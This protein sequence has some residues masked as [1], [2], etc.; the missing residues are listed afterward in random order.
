[1]RF[2]YMTCKYIRTYYALHYYSNI[3]PVDS[4][5]QGFTNTQ[6]SSWPAIAAQ[7]DWHF[8]GLVYRAKLQL[9]RGCAV[10][11]AAPIGLSLPNTKPRRLKYKGVVQETLHRHP[12]QSQHVEKNV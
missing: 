1:M 10:S 2:Y 3:H 11:Q 8:E 5:L 9:P 6:T 12:P 7:F 4:I